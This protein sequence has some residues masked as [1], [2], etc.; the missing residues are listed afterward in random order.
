MQLLF[1]HQVLSEN[2]SN[3]HTSQ[4]EESAGVKRTPGVERLKQGEQPEGVNMYA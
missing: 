1:C 3:H 2:T 4:G